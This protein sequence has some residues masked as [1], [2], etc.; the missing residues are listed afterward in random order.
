[1]SS[2]I[3][4]GNENTSPSLGK[5]SVLVL[6]PVIRATT[7]KLGAFYEVDNPGICVPLFL[8]Q[9]LWD[10]HNGYKC[11]LIL[12]P[13][14]LIHLETFFRRLD[15]YKT[16]KTENVNKEHVTIESAP[17]YLWKHENVNLRKQVEC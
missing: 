12:L 1:M 10:W 7:L 8:C 16:K 6:L 14:D 9:H 2:G 15:R 11:F 13:W 5:F 17:K 3:G 4:G